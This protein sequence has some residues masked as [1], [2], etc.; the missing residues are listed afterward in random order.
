[1]RILALILSLVCLSAFAEV[2]PEEF[3]KTKE[4]AD[5]GDAV[6]QY[7]LG[8]CYR[9]GNG[10]SNDNAEAVKWF[11]KS[12][13]QGYR[14]AQIQLVKCFMHGEGVL[15]NYE[16]ADKWWRYGKRNTQLEAFSQCDYNGL[17]YYNGQGALGKLR[18]PV[19]VVKQYRKAAEQGDPKAQNNLGVCYHN[20]EGVLKDPVEG[21]KWFRKSADQG[22]VL[23][24][25]NLGICY[26]GGFGVLKDSIEAYAYYYL[27]GITGEIG[28]SNYN[29]RNV[30]WKMTPAQIEVGQKRLKEL[31]AEIEAK[32]EANKK[33]EKK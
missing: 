5:Q 10:V 17:I 18:D 13:E 26:V 23:A 2:T 19:E 11:R 31:E 32:I 9:W 6:A 14:P 28:L 22:D 33:A 29:R 4:L 3:K 27:A 12:A 25:L 1:M 8:Y 16:E 7:Y 30:M 24:Q 21:V 20:G 15:E